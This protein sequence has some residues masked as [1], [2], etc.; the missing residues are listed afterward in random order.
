MNSHHAYDANIGRFSQDPGFGLSTLPAAVAARGDAAAAR[1][2]GLVDADDHCAQAGAGALR[3]RRLAH[4][5]AVLETLTFVEAGA[6]LDVF[7]SPSGPYATGAHG[8]PRA[9]NATVMLFASLVSPMRASA[10][11]SDTFR[12]E[13]EPASG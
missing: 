8:L 13:F 3:V 12:H 11:L 6:S 9:T 10:D 7:I 2:H 5:D 1:A 4:E